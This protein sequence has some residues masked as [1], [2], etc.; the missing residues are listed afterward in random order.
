MTVASVALNM[1]IYQINYQSKTFYIFESPK[2]H[3]GY[4]VACVYTLYSS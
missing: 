3:F 2:S 1:Q 4:V